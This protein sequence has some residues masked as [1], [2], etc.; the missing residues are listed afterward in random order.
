MTRYR[1]GEVEKLKADNDLPALLNQ[2]LATAD[3]AASA[4]TRVD[5]NENLILMEY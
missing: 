2:L 1:L 3:S 4:T 5:A